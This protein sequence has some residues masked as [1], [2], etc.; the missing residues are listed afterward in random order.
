MRHMIREAASDHAIL[1]GRLRGDALQKCT[2]S[3][4][5]PLTVLEVR[6][7][8]R[9]ALYDELCFACRAGIVHLVHHGRG[10]KIIPASVDEE[11][12]H[13]G[14]PNLAHRLIL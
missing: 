3:F 7:R 2:D 8:M 11:E 9:G 13:A 6:H 12:G 10:H 14:P 4:F 1:R 5:V